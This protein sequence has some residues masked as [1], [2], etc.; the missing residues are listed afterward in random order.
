MSEIHQST[1]VAYSAAQMFELV[2]NVEAYPAFLPWC[3]AALVLSRSASTSRVRISVR[4]GV[5]K[6]T[7]TT[8]NYPQAP[9]QLELRLVDGPFKQLNGLW[10]FIDNA[11]GSRVSLDLR[12]EFSNRV[13]AATLSP[14]FKAVTSS[15]VEAF[16]QRATVVYGP[17]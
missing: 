3:D 11:L 4:K 9:C 2:N 16:K 12:F 6:Y 8:D 1:S 5:L 15:M 14:L 7:F 17:H 13:V 10:R